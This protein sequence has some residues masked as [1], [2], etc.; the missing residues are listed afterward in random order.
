MIHFP[1]C[2]KKAVLRSCIIFEEATAPA[3]GKIFDAALTLELHVESQI[4]SNAQK[5][6]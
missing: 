2:V 6:T 3:P 1:C 4:F 5:K